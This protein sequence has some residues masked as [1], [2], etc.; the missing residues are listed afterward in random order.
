MHKIDAPI[1]C[2]LY[3]FPFLLYLRNQADNV[4]S[5]NDLHLCN[6]SCSKRTISVTYS[7]CVFVALGFQHTAI[8]DLYGCII[9]F[10]ISSSMARFLKKVLLLKMNCVFWFYLKILPETFLI[11][12]RTEG[13]MNKT[14][15]DIHVK[16]LLFSSD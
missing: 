6:Q 10:H 9:F 8:C 7:K 13:D 16:Y 12:R 2:I 14:F 15:I 5:N 4:S 11:L 1:G 3:Q